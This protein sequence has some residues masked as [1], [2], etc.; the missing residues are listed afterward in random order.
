[1]SDLS[2]ILHVLWKMAWI[3]LA[4]FVGVVIYY[5]WNANKIDHEYVHGC[6]KY[7]D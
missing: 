5:L 1:M 3:P 7:E 4:I 2:L 6:R